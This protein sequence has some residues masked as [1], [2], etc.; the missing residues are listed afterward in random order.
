M[1]DPCINN[2]KT[3]YSFDRAN[4]ITEEYL[5]E[6][7]K[8]YASNKEDYNGQSFWHIL[9]D[10]NFLNEIDELSKVNPVLLFKHST[11]CSISVMAKGALDRNWTFTDEDIKP[12]YL[13]L[14][15]YRNISNEIEDRYKVIH[16]SPQILIIKNG[17]CIYNTSHSNISVGEI[18]K[19]LK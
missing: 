17:K 9:S 8:D 5:N 16:A 6:T 11:R 18:K 2:Y 3:Q 19:V 7:L 13:D 14:L 15:N 12:Y 10:V 1:E 4:K